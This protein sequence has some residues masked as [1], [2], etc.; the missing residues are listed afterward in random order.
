MGKEA[1]RGHCRTTEHGPGRSRLSSLGTGARG[2]A[3]GHW[4]LWCPPRRPDGWD[5]TECP[6]SSQ[7]RASERQPAGDSVQGSCRPQ[8]TTDA[9]CKQYLLPEDSAPWALLQNESTEPASPNAQRLFIQDGPSCSSL[10]RPAQ[11]RGPP[12]APSP[13]LGVCLVVQTEH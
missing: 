4:C 6:R 13:L 2:R 1:G 11:I 9:L 5:L 3:L 8:A 10:G 12:S 7:H